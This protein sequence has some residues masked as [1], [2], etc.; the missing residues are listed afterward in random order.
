MARPR[1]GEGD[2]GGFPRN[3][4]IPLSRIEEPQMPITQAQYDFIAQ[5]AGT[6]AADKTAADSGGVIATLVT[7]PQFVA[8]VPNLISPDDFYDDS[9]GSASSSARPPVPSAGIPSPG[10]PGGGPIVPIPTAPPSPIPGTGGPPDWYV[11][12]PSGIP[13]LS[14]A[15]LARFF[16]TAVGSF[17]GFG[18]FFGGI[19]GKV[20]DIWDTLPDVVQTA[21]RAVGIVGVADLFFDIP[22]IPGDF[23]GI[24]GIGSPFG[25]S[26]NPD[27]AQ[28]LGAVI[29]GGWTAN[30]VRF[31]RLADGRLAVQNKRGRW[32]VWR[33]KKPIVLYGTGASD[34]KTFLRADAVLNRQSKKLA[35]ALKRRAPGRKPSS[36]QNA[37]SEQHGITQIKN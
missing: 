3:P 4:P 21:L 13:I 25:G 16:P 17:S 23:P 37:S 20:D 32:K 27:I 14:A 31:Y 33:P 11:M 30:G 10:G 15:A 2:L 7:D 26:G 19:L 22:G 12:G 28:A 9:G 34:L 5:T 6:A 8:G 36:K 29:V 1:R 24:P 35:S 18:R